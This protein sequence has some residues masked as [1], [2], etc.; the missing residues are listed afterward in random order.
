MFILLLAISTGI[1][2]ILLMVIKSDKTIARNIE[3]FGYLLL[4]V[5]LIWTSILTVPKKWKEVVSS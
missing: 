4:V 1:F 5:S 3:I 2:F